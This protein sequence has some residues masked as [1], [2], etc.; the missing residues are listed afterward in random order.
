MMLMLTII[1]C[2]RKSTPGAN[3]LQV[4]IK[5]KLNLAVHIETNRRTESWLRTGHKG[6]F[7]H[8]RR[9]LTCCFNRIK[10]D[11]R[12]KKSTLLVI[13]STNYCRNDMSKHC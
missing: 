11:I 3:N 10:G 4:K 12:Q 8:L 6:K 2:S 5:A 9:Q 13:S 1:D 7:G